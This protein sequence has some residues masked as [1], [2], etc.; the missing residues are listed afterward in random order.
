M[1]ESI[2]NRLKNE[3]ES[4]KNSG[5]Y[6][7]ERIIDRLDPDK[8]T[9]VHCKISYYIDAWDLT[10]SHMYRKCISLTDSICYKCRDRYKHR[11]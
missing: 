4:I 5:R 7:S 9:C 1:H 6:K 11:V 3:L 2:K 8:I 10:E